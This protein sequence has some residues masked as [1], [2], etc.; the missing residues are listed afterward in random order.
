MRIPKTDQQNNKL[1]M[2]QP[3]NAKNLFQHQHDVDIGLNK[4]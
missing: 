3:K 4:S 2:Y 1:I